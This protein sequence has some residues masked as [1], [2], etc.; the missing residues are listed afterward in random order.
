MSALQ[1]CSG[2]NGNTYGIC[3]TVAVGVNLLAEPQE[4]R[5]PEIMQALRV[6]G[7]ST[8]D[9]EKELQRLG[10]RP[11]NSCHWHPKVL[12]DLCRRQRG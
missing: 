6:A 10:L 3:D 8:R 7:A 2:G 4:V 11:R 12:L 9:I 5:A 1:R